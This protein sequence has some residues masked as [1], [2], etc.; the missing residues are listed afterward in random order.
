MT[1]AAPRASVITP[2]LIAGGVI[3][4]ISFALRSGFGLFQIPIAEQFGWLR[5]EYSLAI[6]IQNLAWGFGQPVFGMIAERWGDRKALALG[7]LCYAVGLGL[8]SA[9]VTPEGHQML[10]ILVG[11]GI[12]GTGIGVILSMVGR[13]T[14]EAHRSVALGIATAAASAGQVF[15]PPVVERLLASMPLSDVFLTLAATALG[16]LMVLPFLRAPKRVVP[17]ATDESFATVVSRALRDPSFTLI[18]LGFFS[19][20]YQLGFITAHFPAFIAEACGPIDPAGLLAGAGITTT[21]QLGAWAIA[22]IGITNVA[23]T[24]IAGALGARHSRKY[25]LSGIYVGRTII[26]GAF[27]LLPVTPMSVLLFSAG[28]GALWLATVPLTAGLVGHI[29]GIRYMGTLFGI[30]FLSHQIGSF[31]GVWLGGVL[32]DRYGSYDLV[33]WIGVGVGAFSAIVHLP[34]RERVMT[35]APAAA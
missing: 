27:I 12:A 18:F 28:M 14:P 24:L 21:A 9:A 30:V 1:I 17:T 34:V 25:L 7:A 11:F 33:W 3:V 22:A 15:G 8:S 16:I 20:G 2:V 23:G 19:C 4:M 35:G 10:N 31:T 29:Y 32:Y 5:T 26:A 6:A 13:A